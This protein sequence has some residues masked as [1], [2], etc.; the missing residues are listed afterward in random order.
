MKTQINKM[1][2]ELFSTEHDWY[3]LINKT[4]HRFV[5]KRS[6]H[7]DVMTDII[8]SLASAFKGERLQEKLNQTKSEEEVVKLVHVAI[9]WR[10]RTA[11]K[12]WTKFFRE[13][14]QFS[15]I[16]SDNEYQTEFSV[17]AQVEDI[18]MSSTLN[19]AEVQDQIL[20]GLRGLAEK[21]KFEKQ[22]KLWRRYQ[23]GMQVLPY[24]MQNMSV[25]ELLEIF[26]MSRYRMLEILN[27][28]R[29]IAFTLGYCT[30]K[31]V[32]KMKTESN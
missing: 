20:L 12:H 18:E 26:E 19:L 8:T 25:V 1:F 9:C 16:E 15:Q 29:R 14:V 17:K 22:T 6:I 31:D 3:G 21:A 32:E 13:A 24:R 28:F 30:L 2:C 27:D 11:R 7:D 23:T 5:S 4:V 10:M